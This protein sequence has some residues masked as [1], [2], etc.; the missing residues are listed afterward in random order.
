MEKSPEELQVEAEQLAQLEAKI[1]LESELKATKAQLDE[2]KR[3]SV[4]KNRKNRKT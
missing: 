3:S 1:Q 2:E 4:Q